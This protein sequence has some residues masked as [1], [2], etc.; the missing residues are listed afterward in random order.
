[1][2]KLFFILIFIINLHFA[3][4][5][6]DIKDFEIEGFSIGQSL[7]NHFSS[8]EIENNRVNYFDEKKK[9]Y[10]V[11]FYKISKTY[12]FI[13]FYLKTSDKKFIVHGINAGIF[14]HNDFKKCENKKKQ[15][16]NEI[17]NIFDDQNM[18][19]SGEFSHIYDKTGESKQ[20]VVYFDVDNGHARVE[21]VNWSKKITKEKNWIDNLGVAAINNELNLWIDNGYQ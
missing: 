11:G 20:S 12:D 4:Y 8:N 21:C 13:E 9:F 17:R 5:S 6:D 2:K 1:M 14:Y 18:I 16:I 15:I 7:L 3:A 19:D 10:V